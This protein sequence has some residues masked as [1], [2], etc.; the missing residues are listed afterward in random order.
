MLT[1]KTRK[2][3]IVLVVAALIIIVAAF[4][5]SRINLNTQLPLVEEFEKDFGAWTAHADV[6][7]NPNNPGSM[8]QWHIHRSLNVS[9]SGNYSAE[10]S[11]DGT[12]DDGVIW[13][14]RTINVNPNT[15]TRISLSFW[16]FSEQESFNTLAAIVAY[17]GSTKPIAEEQ[18]TVI[19][20]ANEVAGWKNYSLNTTV[21]T[22]SAE[23][24]VA[25]G[26]SVLWETY[27]TYY[28]DDLIIE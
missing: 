22:N 21:N 5:I 13:L 2:I 3:I 28:I 24:F 18:F 12:Q 10:F 8:V 19:G 11:I 26:I 20:T 6:P 7:F 27:M 15:Q 9:R 16:L 25:F 17:A 4:L 23:V 14:E 1:A